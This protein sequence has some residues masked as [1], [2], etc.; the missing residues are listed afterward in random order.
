M[1]FLYTLILTLFLSSCSLSWS[2]SQST[3][4]KINTENNY[5]E[6]I[7]LPDMDNS[8]KTEPPS[9]WNRN[10]NLW[11]DTYTSAS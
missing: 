9:R 2:N 5:W 11:I 1:K 8:N 7:T 6:T 10:T 3:D 4:S